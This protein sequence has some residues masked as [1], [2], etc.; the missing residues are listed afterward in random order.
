[1][2]LLKAH[3]PI[4]IT[5]AERSGSTLI[6]RIL[7]MCGVWHGHC[8]K[9]YENKRIQHIHPVNNLH[10]F[11]QTENILPIGFY[12]MVQDILLQEGWKGQKWMIKSSKLAQYWTIWHNIYPDAKWLIIRR[13]T[14]DV[15]ESCLKT[16]YMRTFKEPE[17][18]ALLNFSKEEDGWLWWVHQYEQKFVEMMQNGLNCRVVWPDRMVNGNYEQV[19]ETLEWLGIKW[20][21]MIPEVISPLLEKSRRIDQ[22]QE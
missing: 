13:R 11:P 9:M 7:A 10:L 15:I 21:N 12:E 1:M 16:G 20:N 5:G 3:T 14:G 17:N 4:L 18:L 8:N 6:A 22:W 19:K 2:E